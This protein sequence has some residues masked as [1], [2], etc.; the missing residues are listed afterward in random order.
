MPLRIPVVLEIS[1]EALEQIR[2]AIVAPETTAAEPARI[3]AADDP[4]ELPS[5]WAFVE[6]R[7]GETYSWPNGPDEYVTFR[8]YEGSTSAGSIRLALG[9]CTRA[10]VR[11][12]DRKYVITFYLN[13]A[14]SKR[15][16]AE[17]LETDDYEETGDLIAI[18]KGREGSAKM[19]A[20]IDDLPGVYERFRIETYR[21][22]IDYSG[23]YVRLG[24]V[25]H[26]DDIDTMLGHTLI[27]GQTRF[28]FRPE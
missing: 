19:Y 10:N 12:R 28:G 26:E 1:D 20:P 21:D 11:G 8:V 13:P 2:A 23:S 9:E 16:I 5:K 22:R 4:V 6:E 14:G 27:Q 7:K 24:V 18:I 15:P 25:A 17:F 3:S